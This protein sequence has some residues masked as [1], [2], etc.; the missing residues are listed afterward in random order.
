MF[1]EWFCG[2]R[3]GFGVA[4]VGFGVAFGGVFE[5]AF[6]VGFGGGIWSEI[7][8][9]SSCFLLKI[10]ASF[11]RLSWFASGLC[12]HLYVVVSLAFFNSII[13]EIPVFSFD[14]TWFEKSLILFLQRFQFRPVR[15]S[16]FDSL[17]F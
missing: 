3:V 4:S 7:L 9:G 5:V 6:E 17:T 1:L 15:L 8:G 13:V 16:V 12:I 2:F 10:W 11:N 14:F